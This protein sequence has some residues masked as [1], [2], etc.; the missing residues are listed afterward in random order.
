MR[1]R[2]GERQRDIRLP[3]VAGL[4]YPDGRADLE[5]ELDQ[6]FSRAAVKPMPGKLIGMI[7]PHA[8][9]QYSGLTA[10]FAYRR[11]EGQSFDTVV[12]ISPSHAEYFDGISVF[13]GVAYRTPLGDIPVDDGLRREL[14]ENEDLIESS[15]HGHAE[16]HAVEVHLPF[17]QRQLKNMRILPIVMGDQRRP[18]CFHLGKKLGSVL[19]GKSALLIASSDLSHYHAY[20]TANRL[21]GIIIDD[22]SRFDENKMMSDLEENRAEACGGGPIVALLA[23]ARQLGANRTEILHHCNSGDVTGEHDRVVGYLSAAVFGIH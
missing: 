9:Y 10:A 23:A 15:R 5:H 14:L 8:G 20:D 17:L 16:E 4:F 3:V 11:L 21:D 19:H 2:G 12:I 1:I 22:V 13:D 18:Y 6:L 7:A